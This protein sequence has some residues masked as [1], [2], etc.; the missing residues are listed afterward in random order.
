LSFLLET[1]EPTRRGRYKALPVDRGE[2]FTTGADCIPLDPAW[3]HIFDLGNGYETFFEKNQ[4]ELYNLKEDLS[5]HKDLSADMPEKT[6]QLRKMLSSWR[7]AVE[8]KEMW[9]NPGYDHV[10]KD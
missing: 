8:A 4:F 3:T 2:Y 1:L 10:S 5:E 7:K 9:P 6:N